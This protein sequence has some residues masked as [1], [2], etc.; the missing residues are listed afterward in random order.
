MAC[1]P[2]TLTTHSFA[3]YAEPNSRLCQAAIASRRGS[4]PPVGVYFVR[5]SSMALIAAFLMWSGVGKSGSPGPKS[6]I[7][8]PLAF[9]CSAAP[10]TTAVGDTCIRL[11]RLVSSTTSP[12]SKGGLTDLQCSGNCKEFQ[13]GTELCLHSR[14]FGRLIAGTSRDFRAQPLLHDCRD[15]SC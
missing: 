9:N 2:P 10:I 15:Q 14:Q 4:M 11:M 3:V 6:A 1:L 13:C 8:T 7:S 5:F 12:W